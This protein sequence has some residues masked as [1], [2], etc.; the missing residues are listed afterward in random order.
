MDQPGPN[1]PAVAD[2]RFQGLEGVYVVVE[3]V[4]GEWGGAP[5]LEHYL[6]QDAED[7]LRGAG[8]S[9]LKAG[10]WLTASG[11]PH[12]YVKV[13]IAPQSAIDAVASFAATVQLRE[14]VALARSPAV[15]VMAPIWGA[16]AIE[17]VEVQQLQEGARQSIGSLLARFTDAYRAVHDQEGEG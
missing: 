11:A 17:Q 12:V 5:I 4:A 14:K 13:D 9:L 10:E 6:R 3:S 8:L 2:R 16:Q 15:T 7:V 1:P